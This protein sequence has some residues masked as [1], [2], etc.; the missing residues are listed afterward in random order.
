MC[1][2]DMWMNI[3]LMCYINTSLHD[4]YRRCV[5]WLVD[6]SHD[7]LTCHMTRW[8]VTWLVDMSHTSLTCHMSTS[9]HDS[10][11]WC[12]T[13]LID[14]W[15]AVLTYHMNISLM[16]YMNTLICRVT[17]FCGMS[18][19]YALLQG[20]EGWRFVTQW[21]VTWLS[22][23]VTQWYVTLASHVWHEVMD[24]C[25]VA[26]C[27]SVLQCG[28]VCC[29]VVQCVAV[30]CSV[31]QCV[32]VCCSVLQCAAVCCSVLQ[33][34]AVCCSVLQCV[35]VCYSVL[36]CV[37]VCDTSRSMTHWYVTWLIDTWHDS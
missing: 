16:C 14:L 5:T 31:L 1:S 23:C 26:V 25:C 18:S 13:W 22:W 6:M 33:C 36:Q 20:S 19:C 21:G 9:L 24:M 2:V 8:H 10:Y 27:C 34:A 30:C 29:S 3:S 32:A 15:C 4:A 7:S 12:V 37:A 28:A 35:A 11:R 17:R